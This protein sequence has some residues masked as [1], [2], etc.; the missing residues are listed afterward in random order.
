MVPFIYKICQHSL[1][2]FY[3]AATMYFSM[4]GLTVKETTSEL[5]SKQAE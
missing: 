1:P 5:S 4:K 2:Q 3:P